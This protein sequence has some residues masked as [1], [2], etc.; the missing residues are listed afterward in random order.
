[1]MYS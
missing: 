1:M